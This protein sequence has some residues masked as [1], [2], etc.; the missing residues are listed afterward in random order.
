[1][2]KLIVS[3][4]AAHKTAERLNKLLNNENLEKHVGGKNQVQTAEMKWVLNN[5]DNYNL[6]WQHVKVDWQVAKNG[7][8]ENALLSS[9]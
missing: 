2:I 1:M 8:S 3:G 5:Y 9:D 4:W 7:P 6:K